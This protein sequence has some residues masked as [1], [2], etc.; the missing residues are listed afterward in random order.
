[1]RKICA[2]IAAAGLGTRLQNFK[3]NSHTKVL[4]KINNYSM[5]SSQINQLSDWGI[6]KFVVITNP[7]FNDLIHYD[8]SI[9]HPEKDVTF[10]IQEKPLG[11]AHALKQ[12]KDLVSQED[13]I[14][15]VLG[16]NF[17]GENPIQNLDLDNNFESVLFV[18]QVP[19]P[20][21]FGVAN[22]KDNNLISIIEKP[23]NPKSNL[24]V[25]GLYLYTYECFELIEKLKSSDRGELEITD[26]NNLLIEKGNVSYKILKSWWV[27]AGTEDRIAELRNL[28]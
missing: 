11:I 26:L 4:I 19:N 22:I 24:A 1:M 18:K 21:E 27:D 15:F 14:L 10:V 12:S 7:E 3:D 9:H 23:K 25:L 13:K 6:E 28:I 5:I 8:I 17:F 2:V 16:D 20:E